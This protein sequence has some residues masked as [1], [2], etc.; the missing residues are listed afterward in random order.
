MVEEEPLYTVSPN[1]INTSVIVW[2]EDQPQPNRFDYQVREILYQNFVT[3]QWRI[4]PI[5]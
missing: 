4:H 1:V 2:L 3:H 5:T